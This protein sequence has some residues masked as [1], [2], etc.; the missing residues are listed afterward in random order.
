MKK[1]LTKKSQE[2]IEN[3]VFCTFDLEKTLPIPK[4]SPDIAFHL[5]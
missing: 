5:R 2:L 1:Q 4:L 3:T